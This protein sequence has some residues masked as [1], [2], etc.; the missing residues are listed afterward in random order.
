MAPF[1]SSYLHIFTKRNHLKRS[2]SSRVKA[3]EFDKITVCTH[4]CFCPYCMP[5]RTQL[6]CG[7]ARVVPSSIRAP[8]SVSTPAW[9][10]QPRRRDLLRVWHSPISVCRTIGQ[11]THPSLESSPLLPFER[12][13]P[14]FEAFCYYNNNIVE[15]AAGI[16]LGFGDGH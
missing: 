3:R 10:C 5:S 14:R 12:V 1:P 9:A 4:V 11:Y 16:Y 7:N 15:E 8:P 6:H 13:A 2:L